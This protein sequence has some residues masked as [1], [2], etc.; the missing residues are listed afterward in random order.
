VPSTLRIAG[1][2]Q[3]RSAFGVYAFWAYCHHAADSAAARSHWPAIKARLQP[4]LTTNYPFDLQ[5]KT[6]ASDETEIL[7]GNLAGLIGYIRLARRN[8]DAVAEKAALARGVQL[9]ELRVNRER[10]NPQILEPTPSSTKH[11]HLVKLARYCG[12]VPEIGERV[13]TLTDGCGAERLK[14]FR[15]ARNG[16]H[17][18]FG[19]RLIGGE[20]YTNPPH[21]SRALFAGAVFVEQLPARQILDFVDVPWC[22]GDFYFIEKCVSALWADAGR[23][24]RE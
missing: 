18:A 14:R 8:A 20:N 5:K 4:L 22:H 1:R 19:D 10:V 23:R 6:F 11:L 24:W 9:L 13:R 15:E 2:G 17:L 12:M 16:W 3:A 21:F 7:N